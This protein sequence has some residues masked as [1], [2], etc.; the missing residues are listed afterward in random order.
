[1]HLE[2]TNQ[3]R[4]MHITLHDIIQTEV[5]LINVA[6][7]KDALALARG[8][9]FANKGAVLL[10][11]RILAQLERTASGNGQKSR[12]RLDLDSR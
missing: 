3:K 2:T 12:K 5:Y 7:E 11:A 9:G 1:M 10:L 6:R 4:T 8:V